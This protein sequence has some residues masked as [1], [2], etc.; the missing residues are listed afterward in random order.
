M[1][2]S[3]TQRLLKAHERESKKLTMK[4]IKYLILSVSLAIIMMIFYMAAMVLYN[5]KNFYESLSIE[6]IEYDAIKDK[7]CIYMG[8]KSCENSPFGIKLKNFF[9]YAGISDCEKIAKFKIDGDIY[10]PRDDNLNL[11]VK[12]ILHDLS[13]SEDLFQMCI[14]S[15][16]F[17]LSVKFDCYGFFF[18]KTFSFHPDKLLFRK[19]G[20]A[21]EFEGGISMEKDKIDIILR[22]K[23]GAFP[24][25][26]KINI[27]KMIFT[28]EYE[29]SSF[30]LTTTEF[31]NISCDSICFSIAFPECSDFPGSLVLK[32]LYKN[33]LGLKVR[34][35]R[36]HISLKE[37]NLGIL[38]RLFVRRNIPLNQIL[39]YK[40]A[41]EEGRSLH[42]TN[43]KN[44]I[45]MRMDPVTQLII[46]Q[47]HSLNSLHDLLVRHIIQLQ[48]S[49]YMGNQLFDVEI[50]SR[51]CTKSF[52]MKVSTKLLIDQLV[53]SKDLSIRI[54]KENSQIYNV[55]KQFNISNLGVSFKEPQ[56]DI[57][58]ISTQKASKRETGT[59][60][61]FHFITQDEKIQLITISEDISQPDIFHSQINIINTQFVIQS[62]LFIMSVNIHRLSFNFLER[63]GINIQNVRIET[64][65]S[66][67]DQ[68]N[69]ILKEDYF[70][71][72]IKILNNIPMENFFRRNI[73]SRDF[74]D[75]NSVTRKYGKHTLLRILN[76]HDTFD[77]L[78]CPKIDIASKFINN[79][80]WNGDL[81]FYLFA[82]QSSFTNIVSV[83]SI[84][85]NNNS[86]CLRI[87]KCEDNSISL[88]LLNTKICLNKL[89]NIRLKPSKI[90][91]IENNTPLERLIV[92]LISPFD[93]VPIKTNNMI[94]SFVRTN[95][96]CE[97][98][99]IRL[100]FTN[101]HLQNNSLIKENHG[102]I[103]GL[104]FITDLNI[105]NIVS[106]NVYDLALK[107]FLSEKTSGL[108]CENFDIEAKFF[109]E[110]KGPLH[111]QIDFC[112]SKN[113]VKNM[114][115]S[116]TATT[117]ELKQSEMKCYVDIEHDSLHL[118]FSY[119]FKISSYFACFMIDNNYNFHTKRIQAAVIGNFLNNLISLDKFNFLIDLRQ[120][121]K[122]KACDNSP[123]ISVLS[124]DKRALG[125]LFPSIIKYLISRVI[126]QKFKE[127]LHA[128]REIK[129][130]SSLLIKVLNFL[131]T[132]S[133]TE[134]EIQCCIEGKSI[135][136]E[137]CNAPNGA[138]RHG[139]M[140]LKTLFTL[141]SR[142]I[143]IPKNCKILLAHKR[144]GL[145]FETFLEQCSSGCIRAKMLLI[146]V[147]T[148]TKL[149]NFLRI[150]KSNESLSNYVVSFKCNENTLLKVPLN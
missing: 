65:I 142:F 147:L 71:K 99:K 1:D 68:E 29:K 41:K 64:S 70:M 63:G 11:D 105:A 74:K 21:G 107:D 119:N 40:Q 15:K 104:N 24:K 89:D 125:V 82:N 47:N 93:Y 77:I 20:D 13:N 85:E 148:A 35:S 16:S 94:N 73:F 2:H 57:P 100:T 145:I 17:F 10:L 36:F 28:C 52:I 79:I 124:L 106:L 4:F 87:C 32:N 31:N 37:S 19:E 144:N 50:N 127:T 7:R 123:Q 27:P 9:I 67:K 72:N 18:G 98:F 134:E 55:F 23:K 45:F 112:H 116:E 137:L 140:L 97:S 44:I 130:K 131:T 122:R 118:V 141:Q 69:G 128:D 58:F 120:I 30:Y 81:N 14:R 51:T 48:F 61:L 135:V 86:H 76:S 146:N 80:F 92:R 54:G 149:W 143:I 8:I 101:K 88:H 43:I 111:D 84:I 38:S 66:L 132:P 46:I 138:N 78:F 26:L 121:S 90:G 42:K 150:L 39:R 96:D 95:T 133:T 5:M 126:S 49:I 102:L 25:N 109:S 12:L 62:D 110:P 129:N 59:I 136:G 3:I 117:N 56:I 6:Y 60:S 34:W 103:L 114:L 53:I 108:K 139:P 33:Y 83:K 115:S 91:I 113:N 22:L 75:I